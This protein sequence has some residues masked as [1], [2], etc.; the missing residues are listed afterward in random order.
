MFLTA[1]LSTESARIA[2]DKFLRNHKIAVGKLPDGG[3]RLVNPHR[4]VYSMFTSV[5]MQPNYEVHP[6][7]AY[8]VKRHPPLE[9]GPFL[10]NLSEGLALE[11]K[12][13][14]EREPLPH[15][16]WIEG[17]HVDSTMTR[18]LWYY[19]LDNHYQYPLKDL[20]SKRVQNNLVGWGFRSH[21]GFDDRFNLAITNDNKVKFTTPYNSTY[22]IKT[23]VQ[24]LLKILRKNDKN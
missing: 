9:I 16:Y 24:T 11:K 12:T 10:K 13:V 18:H 19:L 8:S 15:S 17:L 4:I 2:L 3:T 20:R 1:K 6:L 22:D 21:G 23:D 14:V 5:P 7:L